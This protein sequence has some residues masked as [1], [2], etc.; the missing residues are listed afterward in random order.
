MLKS[1]K[2][3]TKASSNSRNIQMKTHIS[4]NKLSWMPPFKLGRCL[5]I[6][7]SGPLAYSANH[8]LVLFHR[9]HIFRLRKNIGLYILHIPQQSWYIVSE[10][11]AKTEIRRASVLFGRT[12]HPATQLV[13]CFTL[14]LN[15]GQSQ[16]ISMN[17][18]DSRS[19]RSKFSYMFL[20]FFC[21]FC[22]FLGC[23]FLHGPSP[24]CCPRWSRS[25]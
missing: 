5:I 2:T 21:I 25:L 7:G 17:F 15:F 19:W 1:W 4:S 13:S 12:S 24:R 8:T 9:K 10:T 22:M 23:F 3:I 18:G 16:S 14:L 6:F 20:Y 11:L